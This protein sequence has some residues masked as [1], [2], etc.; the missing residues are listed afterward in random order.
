MY[1]DHLYQGKSNIIIMIYVWQFYLQLHSS[2]NWYTFCDIYLAF[3]CRNV[4]NTHIKS[5]LKYQQEPLAFM[6]VATIM[7]SQYRSTRPLNQSHIP[8][9]DSTAIDWFTA[10][11]GA[12]C[13]W[14]QCDCAVQ[15]YQ[16]RLKKWTQRKA[17]HNRITNLL[18]GPCNWVDKILREMA[19][20]F[21]EKPSAP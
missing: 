15:F 3:W 12:V 11:Y 16:Q 14:T 9:Y 13:K 7:T 17:I 5:L 2:W 1:L 6:V 18:M 4:S 8:M 20:L 19:L 10:V 21:P